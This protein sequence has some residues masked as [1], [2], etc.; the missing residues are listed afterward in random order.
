MRAFN[1]TGAQEKAKLTE[2]TI[3][4]NEIIHW[5]CHNKL[6]YPINARTQRSSPEAETIHPNNADE[7]LSSD[8]LGLETRISDEDVFKETEILSRK[9]WKL[10]CIFIAARKVWR[11]P[12]KLHTKV[13]RNVISQCV[14]N[15]VWDN[16]RW[17]PKCMAQPREELHH[18]SV[19]FVHSGIY[20][21]GKAHIRSTRNS[22]NVHL[23]EDG[24]SSPLSRKI[25]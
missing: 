4:S 6:F 5:L 8:R 9:N 17:K 19:N 7:V 11:I 20:A 21:L 12:R 13:C 1:S 18:S 3:G 24:P 2:T 23:L 25:V 15:L 14:E 16:S 22:F 10:E